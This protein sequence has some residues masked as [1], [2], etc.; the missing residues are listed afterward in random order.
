MN[1]LCVNIF[2]KSSLCTL[3]SDSQ[4]ERERERER[5]GGEGCQYSMVIVATA[6]SIKKGHAL[7]A[8]SFT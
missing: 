1:T 5:G 2:G 4:R 6:H 3:I 7:C 8:W